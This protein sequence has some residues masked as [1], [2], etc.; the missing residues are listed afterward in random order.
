MLFIWNLYSRR[1]MLDLTHF[2]GSIKRQGQ[3]SVA[4]ASPVSNSTSL[5]RATADRPRFHEIFSH[6]VSL[7]DNLQSRR[8]TAM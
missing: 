1:L 8:T 2:P 3:M 7:I 5:K 6:R 4:T